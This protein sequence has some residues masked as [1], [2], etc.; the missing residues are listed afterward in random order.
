MITRVLPHRCAKLKL[1]PQFRWNISASKFLPCMW[2]ACA[3]RNHPGDM[4]CIPSGSSGDSSRPCPVGYYPSSLSA[5]HATILQFPP[6][7]IRDFSLHDI[8][9]ASG[10]NN[11]FPSSNRILSHSPLDAS[12]NHPISEPPSLIPEPCAAIL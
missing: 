12:S 11:H 6:R 2:L 3:A 5:S 8:C 10:S 1:L 4:S 7:D 9:L